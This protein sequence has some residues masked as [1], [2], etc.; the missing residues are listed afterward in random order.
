VAFVSLECLDSSVPVIIPPVLHT[1]QSL[2]PWYAV[3]SMLSQHWSAVVTLPLTQLMAGFRVRKV[4]LSIAVLICRHEILCHFWQGS[5]FLFLN[6]NTVFL[7][8]SHFMHI[9]IEA[10]ELVLNNVKRNVLL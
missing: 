7:K 4:T 6:C 2:P 9:S 1:C 8:I 3:G 5:V 10:K